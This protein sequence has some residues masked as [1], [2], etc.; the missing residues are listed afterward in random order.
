MSQKTTVLKIM[1]ENGQVSR[2]ACINGGYGEIITRLSAIILNLRREGMNIETK[3][4]THPKETI[5]KL[6]DKPK[7]TIVYRVNGEVVHTKVIY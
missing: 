5:Y 6:M 7:E 3:E 4:T 2:N 1:R